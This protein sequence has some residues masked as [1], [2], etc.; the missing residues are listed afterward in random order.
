[1]RDAGGVMVRV[2]P[3]RSVRASMPADR[4]TVIC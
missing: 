4:L 3:F 1:M 2:L